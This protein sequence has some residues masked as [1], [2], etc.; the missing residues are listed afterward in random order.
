MGKK[1]ENDPS[2]FMCS[3]WRMD[4]EITFPSTASNSI[5][6]PFLSRIRASPSD[7][8]P[9]VACHHAIYYLPIIPAPR[10][11]RPWIRADTWAA[12]PARVHACACTHRA[13]VRAPILT[14][15][16]RAARWDARIRAH[17]TR[18][19]CNRPTAGF[20]CADCVRACVGA[21]RCVKGTQ[22]R[23]F[24]RWEGMNGH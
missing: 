12:S 14:I 6:S 8:H 11:L 13:N 4:R 21:C 2:L 10:R 20:V 24:N 9:V 3:N 22:E 17:S 1:E 18:L 5:V 7:I 23:S 16:S 19:P 15:G